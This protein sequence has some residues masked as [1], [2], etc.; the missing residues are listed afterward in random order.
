MGQRGS[1]QPWPGRGR[2]E[3]GSLAPQVSG[4][5]PGG[6]GGREGDSGSKIEVPMLVP[7]HRQGRIRRKEAPVCPGTGQ[8]LGKHGALSFSRPFTGKQTT[9]SARWFL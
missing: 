9:L 7:H 5:W 1:G 3:G 8:K 6:C 2:R 4:L